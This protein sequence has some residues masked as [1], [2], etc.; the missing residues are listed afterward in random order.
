M[1]LF[2]VFSAIV[3][4]TLQKCI[5]DTDMFKFISPALLLVLLHVSWAPCLAAEF[6]IEPI[7]HIPYEAENNRIRLN[8]ELNGT[9]ITLL[10]DTGASTSILFAE[11]QPMFATLDNIGSTQVTFPAVDQTF[12]GDRLAP[13]SLQFGNLA[14]PITKSLRIANKS[15]LPT[16]LM[17]R[18][19]GI[20][21]QEFFLAY[22]IAVNHIEKILTLY[23]AGT[24]LTKFYRTTHKLIMRGSAPHIRFRS[25][26]SWEDQPTVKEFMIDTG[27]PGAMVIWSP[28]H[29]K[30]ATTAKENEELKALNK[31]IVT[32]SV[33][34]FGRLKY[35]NTPV[36]LKANPPYQMIERDGL[37]GGLLL[38][39]SNYAID[40]SSEK[41]WILPHS[42]KK[43]ILRQLD[44]IIYPPNNED[45][46]I[47]D[48][49]DEIST[50][51]KTVIKG[52]NN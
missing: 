25:Q 50:V 24:D 38:N 32:R 36:F 23:P 41:L 43:G 33:I 10:L 7:A 1:P 17:L 16:Q 3:P 12:S 29:F 14:F 40:F 28:K 52:R 27:Y 11:M 26:L 45:F 22:T 20:L 18:Y 6:D 5:Y 37:I 2:G 8:A 19:D 49:P 47:K 15:S 34:R 9:P 4:C 31:G 30:Q 42:D 46:I 35:M 48:Y 51:M 44:N 39:N 13:Y 21:G